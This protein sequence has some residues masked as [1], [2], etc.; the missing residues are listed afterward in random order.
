M[1]DLHLKGATQYNLEPMGSLSTV[2]LFAIIALFILIIA[3]INYVNLATAKSA[4]RAKEVGV[5]KVSGAN[6]SGLIVQFISESILIVSFA[7]ILS[8]LLV[9]A[10][11]PVFNQLI[12]KELSVGLLDT[13]TG[14]LLLL[15]LIFIVGISAGAYPAFVLSSFSPISV[16]KGT[17]NP[18]SMSKNLRGLLVVFQ[19]TVSIVIIIGSI[20]VYNQLSFMTK[21]DLGFDKNNLLIIRRPDAFYKQLEPFRNQILQING[22]EKVGFSRSV[23]GTNYNNNAFLNDEDPEKKTYLLNQT[24]VSLDYPQALGVELVEGRFFSR[25]YGTDS[26]CVLINETA[27][28]SLG[29]KDPIGKFILQPQGRAGQ[30][31]KFKIIGV[32]KDFN[33][34]TLHKAISPVCFTVMGTG[35][36][37]MFATIRLTGNDMTATLGGN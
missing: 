37:D 28:K 19:F 15:G 34:E 23:P 16:L 1:K 36:G 21:K 24:Q 14:F 9:Y 22:V 13:F 27:V 5:R 12:G 4:A 2:Y 30:F 18:G 11:T 32:M 3:V 26:T 7:A 6:K 20:I 29:L 35:G 8:V 10:L 33:I 25:D 31:Q 17:L